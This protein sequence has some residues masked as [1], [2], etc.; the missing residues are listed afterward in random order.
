[1]HKNTAIP[2]IEFGEDTDYDSLYSVLYLINKGLNAGRAATGW[3]LTF[4]FH[5]A[6]GQVITGTYLSS[7]DSDEEGEW[8]TIALHKGGIPTG[9]RTT[10]PTDKIERIVYL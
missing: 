7:N 9:T 3:G 5:L 6:D 2:A 4:D 1:M 8:L 10:V